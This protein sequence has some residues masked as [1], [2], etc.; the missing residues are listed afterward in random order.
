MLGAIVDQ[1][2]R[3]STAI[4]ELLPAEYRIDGNRFFIDSFHERFL[5]PGST[6][7]DVGGGKQPITSAE[8]KRRL[9]IRVVGVDIS[10]EEL[11]AAPPGCYDEIVCAD[12]TLYR[13]HATADVVICQ[14]L[15]EHVRSTEAAMTALASMLKPGGVLLIFVPSRNAVFARLNLL[16]PQRLKEALL[17]ALFP[18]ARGAQGFVSYYHRCTPRDFERMARANGLDVEERHLFYKSMYFSFFAPLHLIWRLWIFLFRFIRREQAAET[19]VYAF[20]KSA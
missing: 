10:G 19:F 6:V 12:I 17:F 13:G 18:A 16:L 5:H 1:Q 14:A 4:E 11:S 8:R 20:R 7:F 3:W 15:L 2:M 9:G